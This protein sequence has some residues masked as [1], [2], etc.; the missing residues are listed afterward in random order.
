MLKTSICDLFGIEFPIVLAGMG[1]VSLADLAA[2][3]SEAGGLGTIALAGFSPRAI[4]DEIAA[5]R[6]L[7]RKPIAVNLLVPFIRPGVLDALLDEP[8]AAITFF[9][10]ELAEY[11]PRC[12]ERGI[13]VIWQCGSAKEALAAKRAGADVIIVQGNDAGGHV[14]GTVST[15]AL[16]PEVRDLVGE[17][18]IVAAGGL[19]DGRGLAAALAL[20]ADAAAF[21][22]RFLASK[23]SAAHP[24][25][26]Q[27]VV[28][29]RAE[30]TVCL[31]LFDIG[32]PDAPHR[33]LRTGAVEEWERAGRPAS[34]HRPGEG[35]VM[36]ALRRS[37]TE[38]QL[39]KYSVMAPSI[40]F[41]GD[42]EGLPLYAGQSCGIVND[43]PPAGEIVRRIAAEAREVIE[44][45]LAPMAR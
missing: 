14:S 43:I 2:A 38:L 37:G 16:V 23:E 40:Y 34:G 44:K 35:Q 13:K 6:K 15:L 1:G 41:E 10:G 30:D 36:G 17:M 42:V 8:V 27:R 12:K 31:D 4:H 26:K 18:P 45:R 22:T 28:Q 3:V 5:A 25:Y 33:V 32:W 21:G 7:T 39:V 24:L 19:A 29:A 11:V 9:W 20:G